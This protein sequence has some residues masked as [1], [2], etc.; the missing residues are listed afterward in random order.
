MATIVTKDLKDRVK[1]DTF[2]SVNFTLSDKTTGDPIDLT[3]ISAQCQFRFSTK[4]GLVVLDVTL[5][6]G[7]TL[8]DA[9]NGII[10]IEGFEPITWEVG[11]D[12]Y[13]IQITFPSEKIK[14]YVQGKVTILQDTTHG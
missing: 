6:S 12:K 4:L 14:T 3:G 2:E 9:V 1:N 13:D 5:G 11:C 7:L 8:T 10:T